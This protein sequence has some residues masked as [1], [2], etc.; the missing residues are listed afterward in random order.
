MWWWC[1]GERGFTWPRYVNRPPQCRCECLRARDVFVCVRVYI[2]RG[3]GAGLH[4]EAI[5]AVVL[6]N[7]RPLAL[8]TGEKIQPTGPERGRG[9][10]CQGEGART[11][12][13]IH[14]RTHIHTHTPLKYRNSRRQQ[15]HAARAC[16]CLC[17]C[18]CA[19]VRACASTCAHARV[20][21]GGG[22]EIARSPSSPHLPLS[23][24]FDSLS[25]S[26]PSPGWGSRGS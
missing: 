10:E 23:F 21:G 7:D 8:N 16:K 5:Q 25:T 18:L 26:S 12:A 9:S 22:D 15:P 13:R 1:W 19:C 17:A 24:S 14:A 20:K 2:F 3:G 6:L 11:H 4:S